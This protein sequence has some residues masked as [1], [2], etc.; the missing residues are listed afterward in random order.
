M[1][2]VVQT[3]IAY[4]GKIPSRGDFIKSSN[5]PQLLKTLDSWLARGMEMLAEDP[6]WK[7]IYEGIQPLHF[8]FLGSNS[9]LIIAGHLVASSDE[10]SRRFPFLAATAIEVSR[11]LP[12]LARSPLALARLWMRTAEQMRPLLTKA[13]PSGA[14]NALAQTHVAV[15]IDAGSGINDGAFLDFTEF[16]TLAGLEQILV[17]DGHRVSLRR[18]MLALGLLLQPVM[19]SGSSHLEKG[20]TLPL[21]DDPFYRNLVATFWLDLVTRFLGNADFELATFMGSINGRE[22]LVIGF[23]GASPQTLHGVID[24]R[25]YVEQNIDIDNPEWV[26]DHAASD[27]KINKLASY[28]DQPRLS[29]RVALDTFREAFIGE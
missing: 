15:D 9:R 26:D 23:N 25:T 21:P 19:A 14:L 11:P 27:P 2:H 6:R 7:L 5:H 17:H 8:A 10:S 24:P 20:L 18:S 22:R 4:F 29:L 28:L 13:E 1:T 3:S 16:Q 12:F